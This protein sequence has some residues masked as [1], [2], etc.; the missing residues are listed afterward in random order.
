MASAG[1]TKYVKSHV[2]VL[3]GGKVAGVGGGKE[4]PTDAQCGAINWS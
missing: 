1:G 4:T 2:T 3:G